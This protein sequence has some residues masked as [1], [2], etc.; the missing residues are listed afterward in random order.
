MDR[1]KTI[2]RTSMIGIGAN[3]LLAGFKACVGVLANSIAIILYAVN[4]LSDALSSVITIVGTKLAEKPADEAHPY[5]YG[6]IEYLSASIISVIILYAGITSL[7]ESVK[8]II[9]PS[10][11][12][13][14]TA[15]LVIVV[16]A[17]IVK[18]VLGRYTKRVGEQVNSD[19]LV[20]SGEDARNDAIISTTTLIAA[21]IYIFAHIS[22]EAYLGVIISAVILKSG[23]EMLYGTI[24]RILGESADP[25]LYTDI[26]NT[27][28]SVPGVLGAFDL[29]LHDYGPDR[30]LGSMH[31]T[32][33]D[34][35]TAEQMDKLTRRIMDK[36]MEKHGILMNAIGFYAQNT[37][38]DDAMEIYEKIRDTVLKHDHVLSI[39]GFYTDEEDKQIQF[40][41]VID[42]DEKDPLP[43][44]RLVQEE[45][46][47]LYPDYEIRVGL[48]RAT[49]NA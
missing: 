6:R 33:E 10:V 2:V 11:P 35:M 1:S 5:G 14:S 4:N 8:K 30:Y 48:D 40:D 13:Y 34:T 21:L 29:A 25:Q 47:A 49:G 23:A 17:I 36:V 46:R 15:S 38:H 43:L 28:R 20:N 24:S 22:L 45:C 18:L 31:V 41:V 37:K 12:D 7:V 39:H 26:K 44:Y 42:Y 16:S 19:S 32:V 3:I 27:V 9:S